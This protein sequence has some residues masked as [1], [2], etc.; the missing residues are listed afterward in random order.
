LE[1]QPWVLAAQGFFYVLQRAAH[2][3]G[4]GLGSTGQ[5]ED[6]GALLF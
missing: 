2:W 5:G 6:A 3:T 1:L 4:A